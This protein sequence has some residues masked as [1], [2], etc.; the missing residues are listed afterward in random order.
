MG[1]GGE[2][3]LLYCLA[4]L[5]QSV[6]HKPMWG[7]LQAE[8]I[9]SSCI[10]TAPNQSR[11]GSKGRFQRLLLGRIG[12]V[13][14]YTGLRMVCRSL[15][16][17]CPVCF[18]KLDIVSGN[19]KW[20]S[21]ASVDH[22]EA[23]RPVL[24]VASPVWPW[25]PWHHLECHDPLRRMRWVAV[26]LR[27]GTADLFRCQMSGTNNTWSYFSY[28]YI[29]AL[30]FVVVL[31][32]QIFS[33]IMKTTSTNH[34][35]KRT[36]QSIYPTFH[37]GTHGYLPPGLKPP[38]CPPW[39]VL[40]SWLPSRMTEHYLKSDGN[41]SIQNTIEYKLRKGTILNLVRPA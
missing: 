41:Q 14:S 5:F 8:P 27:L 21:E 38:S 15:Q 16:N 32:P 34:Y 37:F 9:A 30:Q 1:G 18:L 33:I 20:L 35:L 6:S 4:S 3:Q 24:W 40:V 11:S 12:L 26:P 23:R 17:P 10:L 13:T 28:N 31:T 25:P 39:S 7:G 22:S 19:Q 36:F 29:I 2:V